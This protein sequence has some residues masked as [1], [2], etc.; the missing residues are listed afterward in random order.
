MRATSSFELDFGF[1]ARLCSQGTFA[2]P[3]HEMWAIPI[4]TENRTSFY[5][6]LPFI[7]TLNHAFFNQ[8][9]FDDLPPFILYRYHLHRVE[10]D[11]I[12]SIM[13]TTDL[14]STKDSNLLNTLIDHFDTQSQQI[15][16]P[17]DSDICK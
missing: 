2:L 11:A 14:E 17:E 6:G 4:L 13:K 15:T 3:Q 16:S 7:Q 10:I 1:I 5:D 12:A 8:S 9:I